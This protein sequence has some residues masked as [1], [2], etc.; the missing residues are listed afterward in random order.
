MTMWTESELDAFPWG[1]VSHAYGSAA[2][3][4]QIVRGLLAADEEDRERAAGRL[5]G[6]VMH[7][8]S[9]FTATG[10]VVAVLARMLPDQRLA[11][12]SADGGSVRSN[13]LHF[14]GQAAAQ[15]SY[16]QARPNT[17]MAMRRDDAEAALY[18][19]VGEIKDDPDHVFAGRIGSGCATRAGLV[20]PLLV[21]WLDATDP[22]ERSAALYAAACW[23]GL[24]GHGVLLPE[25]ALRRLWESARDQACDPQVRLDSVLGLA[26]AGVDTGD[27][28]D[29]PSP[30]V[31]ACAALSPRVASDPRTLPILTTALMS[32][33]E[34]HEWVGEWPPNPFIGNDDLGARLVAAAIHCADGFGPLLPIALSVA[35]A[36]EPW[37]LEETWGPLLEAAFPRRP[38]VGLPFTDAQGEYLMALTGKAAL[39]DESNSLLRADLLGRLGLPDDRE[40]LRS[41]VRVT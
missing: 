1:R 4:P 22:E 33:G 14:L 38:A 6:R 5:W 3:V 31:R 26:G 19:I 2:D 35:A 37:N 41:L 34:C 29:D 13:L 8:G 27:L 17:V 15:A 36:A 7:Q 30:V 12:A 32:V 16:Y 39:W 23:A 28:L 9:L 21:P 18:D 10:P 25:R 40:A 11:V 24:A 20:L